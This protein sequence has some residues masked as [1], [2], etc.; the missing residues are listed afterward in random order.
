MPDTFS[1][2]RMR[3]EARTVELMIRRYCRDHHGKAPEQCNACCQLL[4]YALKRLRHCPFQE[5]KSTCGK[6]PIHCYA[7]DR[8]AQIR[9]VMLHSG[10][11]LISTHPVLALLHLLDGL[12]S[13]RS[14]KDSGPA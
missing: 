9:T 5:R 7:P 14:K 4:A 11:R 10:R 1:S 8:R 3:R 2:R 13:P 6:C 12:R